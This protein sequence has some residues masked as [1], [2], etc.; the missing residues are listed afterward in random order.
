M[1]GYILYQNF[2]NAEAL[3]TEIN[4][5]LGL[6][7]GQT[8]TWQDGPISFC[9]VGPTSAYTEFE[10]YAIKVDTNQLDSCLTEEQKSNIINKPFEWGIC[11]V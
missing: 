3:I 7:N 2:Q 5:C 4:T 11:S 10:A 8:L 6:P 1:T 9:S